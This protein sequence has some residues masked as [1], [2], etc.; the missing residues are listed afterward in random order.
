MIRDS[1]SP[2]DGNFKGTI[3]SNDIPILFCSKC[4]KTFRYR[5]ERDNIALKGGAV[6]CND[7]EARFVGGAYD[8]MTVG[9]LK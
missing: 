6:L 9:D 8:G 4:H 7:C 2:H 5:G 3:T 1:K